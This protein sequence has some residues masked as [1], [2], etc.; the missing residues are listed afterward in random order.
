MALCST[1]GGGRPRSSFEGSPL[2]LI[3]PTMSNEQHINTLYAVADCE[4]YYV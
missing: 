2:H 4:C 1:S 3:L